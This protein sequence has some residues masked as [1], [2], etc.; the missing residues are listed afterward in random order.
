MRGTV[1]P[2]SAAVLFAVVVGLAAGCGGSSKSSSSSGSSSSNGGGK[3]GSIN[4]AIVDNPQMKDI[5]ALTPKLF[6]A[7]SGIKVNYTVLDEGT[8]REVTTR[9]VA[10]GGRQ[11]DVA[12][13]GMYEAP[14]FGK[15][16]NIIDLTPKAT[17]DPTY[18]LG[19]L[20]PSVRNGLSADGKLYAAPFYGESSFLMYRKDILKKDGVTMPPH[21][22]W[23]QVAAIARKVNTPNMAGIC[24][25]GKPGWGDLGAALTTVLNT[26][27]AT[28]W[29]AKP[30]GTVDKAQVNQPA[31]KQALQFYTGLIKD[32]GEK[33][34]ANSSFNECLSQYKDG[35]VAMWYDATVA[36]GLLEASDSPVKGKNGYAAAPVNKTPASGWLWSWALAIPKTT[37]KQDLAWKYISFATGPQYIKEAGAQISGGWPAIPPGTRKSTYE[38]PQYKQAARAFAKPTLAAMSA[39]PINNPG[40]TKRPGVPGVQYVGIPEFQDVGNQCTQQFSAVIAGR[41]PIDAA[42]KNCQ[43][44]ASQVGH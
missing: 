31:F 33:D 1:R 40:T 18:N 14:Q 38:I 27:G 3:G 35:K 32:A 7:K 34:A 4:V 28:W 41:T 36:A 29:S 15:A 39:A 2:W 9:D 24:L 37:S 10:A 25:R 13:I 11:F 19:D 26:F 21:P 22:T 42:L 12:M 17:A 23:A 43:D 30:D 6:T 16:G 20:I 5:A 44:I 8:L